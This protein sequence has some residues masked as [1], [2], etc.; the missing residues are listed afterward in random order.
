M[1]IGRKII[2]TVAA[3]LVLMSTACKS[4]GKVMDKNEYKEHKTALDTG[5]EMAWREYGSDDGEPVLLIHGITD[6][7]TSWEQVAPRLAENGC[8]C[9]CIEYRG[10]GGTD[11]PDNMPEGYTAE[12]IAEDIENFA[13]KVIKEKVHVV[14]H[15]FGS[16]IA[17]QL[18]YDAPEKFSSSVLMDTTVDM[19]ESALGE[20]FFGEDKFLDSCIEAGSMPVDFVREWTEVTNEDRDFAERIFSHTM[21]IPVSA[22]ENLITGGCA[23]NSRAFAGDIREDVLI[24]WGTEDVL[25][26][27]E[28]QDEV[29]QVMSGD[30]FTYVD[31]EGASHNGHWDSIANAELF[32]KYI[33]YWVKGKDI[34]DLPTKP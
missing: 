3:F 7:S 26:P 15:S 17:Q 21:D 6:G 18:L 13:D 25:C 30:N 9:Y 11:K 23:F 19:T 27:A 22:W 33:E 24:L 4:G 28:T 16:A 14:G 20:I 10:N 32:A 12:L 31:I 34:S 5:I 8:H 2:S 29:K 1:N